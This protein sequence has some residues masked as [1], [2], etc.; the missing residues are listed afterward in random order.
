MITTFNHA[1]FTVPDLDRALPFWTEALGFEA[2]S[3]SR[4]SGAWQETVT[5]V[6]GAQIKVAHLYGHGTHIELIQ[7][8][9]GAHPGASPEPN[10]T[11]AAHVC[12]ECTD[13]EATWNQLMA[14]GAKPQGAIADITSG[15]VAGCKAAYLRDPS[16][17]IIELVEL[18]TESAA[19]AKARS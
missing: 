6:K 3:N 16:G 5:G 9:E 12:F 11:C 18:M 10:A 17:I 14:A 1:S 4:R 8:L 15:P 7:Y 2:R 13:I 19:K